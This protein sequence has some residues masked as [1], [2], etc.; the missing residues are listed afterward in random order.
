MKKVLVIGD[1]ISGSGLTQVIFNIFGHVNNNYQIDA[2]AYGIDPTDFTDKKCKKLG[3]KIHRVIPVTKNPIRHWQWWKKFFK[4]HEYDIIYFNYSASW[5]YLPVIYA[6]EY[7]HAKIICHS[8]N[9]YY[10]HTFSNALMMDLLNMVNNHGKKVFDRNADV[11]IA[12]SSEAGKW[13]FGESSNNVH[14][15]D[16]GLVLSKYQYDSDQRRRIRRRLQISSDERLIGFVGVMQDRKNPLFA[17]NVFAKYH[18]INPNSK[19]VILG[20]GPLKTQINEQVK[21][22]GLE[23]Y[24]TQIDFVSDVNNWYSA[25]DALLFTS[26]YEGFGLVALE[27]QISNLPVLASATNID[28]IFATDNIYKISGL[29]EEKWAN[30]LENIFQ[31]SKGIRKNSLDPKLKKFGIEKQAEKIFKL[32]GLNG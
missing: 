18:K 24:V 23:K 17:L 1:F 8:H 10:S 2:V 9:A 4:T 25:M 11:K 30:K 19:F 29:N 13:M 12:T 14:V 22:L 6:K 5:N 21:L 31:S 26:K 7:C 27:A 16:N 3:W 15:I 28:K 32:I 20:K